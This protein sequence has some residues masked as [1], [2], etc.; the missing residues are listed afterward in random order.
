MSVFVGAAIAAGA[1]ADSR[2]QALFADNTPSVLGNAHLALAVRH[3]QTGAM[4][5]A[6]CRDPVDR[7]GFTPRQHY[8]AR[9]QCRPLRRRW[10]MTLTSCISVFLIADMVGFYFPL[11]RCY[12][13]APADLSHR[14]VRRW[15]TR[16]CQRCLP[17]A[18][19]GSPKRSCAGLVMLVM[20]TPDGSP[21]IRDA[22]AAVPIAVA[23]SH[24]L[25]FGRRP[26]HESG[27]VPLHISGCRLP[28]ARRRSGSG[29]DERRRRQG[30]R[31]RADPLPCRSRWGCRTLACH[32]RR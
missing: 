23:R 3:G 22:A 2:A 29:R 21:L 28:M 32:W 16:A 27:L 20:V 15:E 6:G 10:L 18:R 7:G 9:G 14:A 13:S 24:R 4:L 31:P 30:E 26:R 25:R 11:A 8:G 12:R 5:L 19:A 1:R 17:Q